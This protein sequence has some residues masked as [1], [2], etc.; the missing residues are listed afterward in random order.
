M[1]PDVNWKMIDAVAKGES[2]DEDN[3]ERAAEIL[4]GL[5]EDEIQAEPE[6]MLMLFKSAMKLLDYREKAFDDI[7][8]EQESDIEALKN[9]LAEEKKF[10]SQSVPRDTEYYRLENRRLMESIETYRDEKNE[11]RQDLTTV[12]EDRNKYEREL[13]E[14]KRLQKQLKNE[15]EELR[16]NLREYRDIMENQQQQKLSVQGQMDDETREKF[17]EKNQQISDLLTQITQLEV[18]NRQLDE[19]ANKLRNEMETGQEDMEKMVEEYEKM[20]KVIGA[21]DHFSDNLHRENAQLKMQV[22]DLREELR[23]KSTEEDTIAQ[24]VNDRVKEWTTKLRERDQE[25]AEQARIIAVLRE[26]ITATSLDQDR[27]NAERLTKKLEV[28][29]KELQE[30][31]TALNQAINDLEEQTAIVEDLRKDKGTN[32]ETLAYKSQIKNLQAQIQRLE[33]DSKEAEAQRTAAEQEAQ[34]NDTKLTEALKRVSLLESGQYGLTEAVDEIKE[35][36]HRVELREK[37]IRDLTRQANQLE[38]KLNDLLEENDEYRE[39][40]G[41][42]PRDLEDIINLRKSRAL[43]QQQYRAENQ[44]LLKEIDR[45]EEER[46]EFKKQ[47]RRQAQSQTQKALA[48]GLLPE[49]ME[50]VDEFMEQLVR[51]RNQGVVDARPSIRASP[52]IAT[53][54]TS[55]LSW[56]VEDLS[57]EAEEAEKKLQ[58]AKSENMRLKQENQ[59]VTSEN[60]QLRVAMQDILHEIKKAQE[61]PSKPEPVHIPSLERLLHAIESRYTAGQGESVHFKAQVDQLTGRNDE[62]RSE[63]R[64]LREEHSSVMADKKTLERQVAQLNTELDVLG[65]AAENG[66]R[67]AMTTVKMPQ[68]KDPTTDDVI[69]ALNE[70]LIQVMERDTKKQTNTNEM[71]EAL[72]NSRRQLQ[73]LRQQTHLIYKEHQEERNRW[74]KLKK[75]LEDDKS[76]MQEGA[77]KTSIR[78]DEYDRLLN[79]LQ[80][81]PDDLKQKLSETSRKV[82]LLRV[83][84]KTLIRRHKALEASEGLL[85]AENTRLKNEISQIEKAVSE[86]IGYLERYKAMASFKIESLQKALEGCVPETELSVVNRRFDELTAKYRDLLQKENQFVARNVQIDATQAELKIVLEE[87][88]ALR[89]E[90]AIEKEKRHTLEAFVKRDSSSLTSSSK[91]AISSAVN[92]A[93]QKVTVL[94]MKELNERQKAEHATRMY[95]QLRS[96]LDEVQVR[97]S[98]L[99]RKFSELT[100]LN[101]AAQQVERDLRDELA[102]VV[103]RSVSD[104]DRKKIIKLEEELAKTKVKMSKLQDISDI[105]HHQL[106]SVQTQQQARERELRSLR[107]QLREFQIQTDQN[108]LIGQL[109]HQILNLQASE[110]DA[111]RKLET[112][113]KDVTKLQAHVIKLEKKIDEKEDAVYLT[114][115][116]ANNRNRQL[117]KTIQSLRQQFSGALPLLQQEKFSKSLVRL[118]EDKALIQEELKRVRMEREKLEDRLA[119]ADIK[120]QGLEELRKA[121]EDQRG[122]DKLTEWSHRMDVIRLQDMKLQRQVVRQGE[123]IKYVESLNTQHERTISSL[124]EDIVLMLKAQEQHQVEW[125]VREMELERLLDQFQSQQSEVKKK[126]RRL[127]DVA[128]TLPDPSLPSDVQLTKALGTIREQINT[129]KSM[130]GQN[131]ALELENDRLKDVRH[132]LEGEVHTRDKIITEL[133]LHVP[134]TRVVPTKDTD[135]TQQLKVAMETIET[136]KKRLSSKEESLNRFKKLL[137]DSRKEQESMI[138]LHE[139]ELLLMQQKI[140]GRTDDVFTRFKQAASGATSGGRSSAPTAQQLQHLDE[141][142]GMV[143]EQDAAMAALM[144]RVRAANADVTKQKRTIAENRRDYEE[145]KRKILEEH[146]SVLKTIRLKLAKKHRRVEELEKELSVVNDELQR[147]KEANTRAPSNAMKNL[148]ARLKAQLEEKEKQQQKL[149]VALTELR[150]DL[151]NQ[152]QENVRAHAADEKDGKNVKILVDRRTSH[153]KVEIEDLKDKVAELQRGLKQSKKTEDTLKAELR[154]VLEEIEKKEQTIKKLKLEIKTKNSDIFQ[155]RDKVKRLVNSKGPDTGLKFVEEKPV[156]LSRE[157]SSSSEEHENK[158]PVVEEVVPVDAAPEQASR[159][160]SAKSRLPRA[161]T[162]LADVEKINKLKSEII[163][164]KEENENL[165]QKL[166][167]KTEEPTKNAIEVAKWEAKKHWQGKVDDLRDKLD[168]KE[169]QIQAIEK[170]GNTLRDTITRLEREKL[171]RSAAPIG[172]P[173]HAQATTEESARPNDLAVRKHLHHIEE[174]SRRLHQLGE[175]NSDLRKEKVLPREKFAAKM[176]VKNQQLSEKL[177]ALQKEILTAGLRQQRDETLAEQFQE[178][179]NSMQG[180]I[181]KLSS[182]ATQLMF[183]LEQIKLDVPRLQERVEFQQNYINLLQSEKKE[184]LAR[185]DRMKNQ[186][187]KKPVQGTSGKSIIELE[188]TVVLMKKVVERVERENE[189][190]KKAPGVVSNQIMDELRAENQLLKNRVHEMTQQIGGQ[191]SMRYESKTQSIDRLIKENERMRKDMDRYGKTRDKLTQSKVALQA[192]KDKLAKELEDMKKRLEIAEKKAPKLAGTGSKGYNSAVTSRML[193]SRLKKSEDELARKAAELAALKSMIQEKSASEELLKDDNDRLREQIEILERFP[194]GAGGSEPNTIRELQIARLTVARLESEKSELAHEADL[195]KQRLRA[196]ANHTGPTLSE[197]S[198]NDVKSRAENLRLE[199]EIRLM[200]QEREKM[201]EDMKKMKEELSHFDTDFFDE[202]EDLKFNYAESVKRNLLYEEQLRS[203]SQQFG[204]SIDISNSDD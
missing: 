82:S 69:T 110:I 149:S 186:Q 41:I 26:K 133:R 53:S 1:A 184:A 199:T 116:E 204:V 79:T 127:E 160:T 169:K 17:N 150:A 147:Q 50:L 56:R 54:G 175:E 195:L 171:R 174:L 23:A 114:R 104:A 148:V 173:I 182:D 94:E 10:S 145:E 152:A 55:K 129:I 164:L 185:L 66:K 31:Q 2:R 194:P 203:F 142:E 188:K 61:T 180:R 44:V 86:R 106:Q 156:K 63:L 154:K 128:Q 81:N 25:N 68:S 19:A 52:R 98:E 45:L 111:Q 95:N 146:E 177:E 193:E 58:Q 196:N 155:L 170:Q 151:V 153:F 83:N 181:L 48:D 91:E 20:R 119:E 136:L 107:Q 113:K 6:K 15:N 144:D 140:H 118:Q 139:R 143:K 198:N 18:V 178:R 3:L 43:R 84:E 60:D 78:L 76:K 5:D 34:E 157:E 40:L 28:K 100:K 39:R 29:E 7:M 85:T 9:Q 89:Q 183:E 51:K 42:D 38:E 165:K 16:Y 179:E 87:A 30:L 46:L 108:A 27:I 135:S 32:R 12:T 134:T 8:Q 102:E 123:Q 59:T 4:H 137:E 166:K 96:S 90:L 172:P 125:E 201:N 62:L 75:T 200:R 163:M 109:H 49:D 64:G 92:A 88:D 101:L 65:K 167:L 176:E 202:I 73:V 122:A 21:S 103:P 11:L 126:A 99:E 197:K 24:A 37:E 80:S 13:E 124:E 131:K 130:Q 161:R 189:Q 120:K 105:S 14:G 71:K 35:H 159:P 112:S 191:L 70:H 33:T 36:K 138:A 67:V 74:D 158:E 57:K 93:L 141:L 22:S 72:E 192:E 115:A 168:K 162:S 187:N 77:E 97:N 117:K 132:N 47:I 190:L 121:I